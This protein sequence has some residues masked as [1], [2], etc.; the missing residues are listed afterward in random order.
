MDE[1]KEISDRYG[2]KIIEDSAHALE[3]EYRG[4]KAGTIGEIGCFSFYATK[5]VMT[6]EGGMVITDNG[7][8]ARKIKVMS[9]HG[10][11]SDAWERSESGEIKGYEVVYPGYKY[12]MTDL[13]ASLGIH[14]LPRIEKYHARRS[15]IWEMYDEAFK[16]MPLFI[17]AAEEPGTRHGR[18]L[19][20]VMLDTARSPVTREA[21]LEELKA[22]KIGAGVHYLAVHLHKYYRDTFGF[23]RGDFPNA[24]WISDRTVSLPLSP[25]LTDSNVQ[26]VISAVRDILKASS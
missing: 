9:L 8:Y 20:T 17:P 24:E 11:S 13:Q 1:I 3:T 10:M 14:Q 18:H 12:N 25:A 5:N 16:D 7:E 15:R 4:K 22:R 19:Y 21:F 23:K 26:S 2:I 6:G